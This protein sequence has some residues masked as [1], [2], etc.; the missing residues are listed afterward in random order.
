MA[1]FKGAIMISK[2]ERTV[3]RIIQGDLPLVR[4]PFKEFEK[5]AGLT[6]EDIL[7][8]ISNMMERGIIRTVGAIIRH[9]KAGYTENALVVWAVPE[10]QC[11]VAGNVLASF[12]EVTHCYER[13][14]LFEG[15]YTIFTMVHFRT[16]KRE[17]VIQKL[18]AASGIKD[19]KVLA[20]EEEYKKSS[21]EYF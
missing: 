8:S 13:T 7:G 1:I 15:K 4:R 21:M 6:E 9:Q 5:H 17:S 3:S 12:P 16:G 11:E 20:S 18:S 14:P 19:F 2:K 10:H